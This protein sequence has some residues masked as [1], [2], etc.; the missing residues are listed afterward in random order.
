MTDDPRALTAKLL[1]ASRF[2]MPLQ[3][4]LDHVRDRRAQLTASQ[5]LPAPHLAASEEMPYPIIDAP[6]KFAAAFWNKRA[7][8]PAPK[9][10]PKPKKPR[11]PQKPTGPT[12]AHP[13]LRLIDGGKGITG[14]DGDNSDEPS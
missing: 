14:G 11:N 7:N 8:P 10:E 3:E 2:A 5:P 13:T 4:A 1:A 12:P 9:P 6:D